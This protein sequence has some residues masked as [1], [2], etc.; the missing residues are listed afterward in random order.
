MKASG[1]PD[2]GLLAAV[3][4]PMERVYRSIDRAVGEIVERARADRVLLLSAHGMSSYRGAPFLLPEILFRLGVAARPEE[5]ADASPAPRASSAGMVKRTARALWRRLP[6][7]ARDTLRPVLDAVR[8]GR[9]RIG[10]GRAL[11]VDASRSRCFALHNGAPVGAIRLNLAGREP[12]GVLR[13]G[14]EADAFCDDLARELLAIVDERTGR[15]LVADVRRTDDLHDG[16][17]REALPDLLVDWTGD[18]PTGT[19][20]HGEGR[21]ATIRASSPAIG[22]V[23]GTN[24]YVRTGDHVPTGFFTFVAPGLPASRRDEPV[25]VTDFHPTVCRLLGLPDPGVDGD[26]VEDLFASGPGDPPS[27]DRVSR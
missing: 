8:P 19:L 23:E 20:A 13:P 5:K 15:P 25:S 10:S 16:P 12:R 18:P 3:G 26:V 27:G 2:P 1:R 4:D 11:G 22:T 7:T 21:G 14:G 9:P 24:S 17:R 6:G